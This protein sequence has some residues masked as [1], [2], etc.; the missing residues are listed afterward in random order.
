MSPPQQRQFVNSFTTFRCVYFSLTISTIIAI[1]AS[2][3]D[4]SSLRGRR[5]QADGTG[6][7]RV[8]VETHGHIFFF[9]FSS[10]AQGLP[11]CGLLN[12]CIGMTYTSHISV[13]SFLIKICVSEARFLPIDRHNI[14]YNM[15][16]NSCGA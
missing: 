7:V 12:L 2:C 10:T 8:G 9:F 4:L 11:L 3:S 6:S 13:N 5:I 14:H 16:S 15:H 1:T